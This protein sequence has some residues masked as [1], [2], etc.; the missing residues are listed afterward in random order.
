LKGSNRNFAATA[1]RRRLSCKIGMDKFMVFSWT[2]LVGYRIVSIDVRDDSPAKAG[3]AAYMAAC[4]FALV[5]QGGL[6]EI[7][8]Y[9]VY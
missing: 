3:W 9:C 8:H 1:G 7:A 6:H 4:F 5:L 2:F